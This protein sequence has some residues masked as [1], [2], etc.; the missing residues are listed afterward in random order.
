MPTTQRDMRPMCGV[1]G[2][3]VEELWTWREPNG[4]LIAVAH[5]HGER[6]RTRI[7]MLFL[8]SLNAMPDIHPTVAFA[9]KRIAA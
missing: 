1:C 7:P 8:A 4:D 5:C 9:T 3:K 6:E 2:R